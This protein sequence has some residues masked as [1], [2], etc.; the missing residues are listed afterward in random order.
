MQTNNFLCGI[1][2]R[3]LIRVGIFGELRQRPQLACRRPLELLQIRGRQGAMLMLQ[4]I[5]SNAS[6]TTIYGIRTTE[7]H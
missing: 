5:A 6:G 4:C 2:D 3:K 1:R 7:N